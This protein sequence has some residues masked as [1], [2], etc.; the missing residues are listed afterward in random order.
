MICPKCGAEQVERPECARCGIVVAK[1][2]PRAP[3]KPAEVAP[4]PTPA[5]TSAIADAPA[6]HRQTPPAPTVF[7]APPPSAKLAQFY[8]QLGRQVAAG[9][10]L[11]DALA[12]LL[13]IAGRRTT[14]GLS[15][16]EL[17]RSR[18][19][20]AAEAADTKPPEPGPGE[21]LVL[22]M[23]AGVNYN[24]IWAGL[25]KPVSVLDVTKKDFHIAGSDA[26]GSMRSVPA[27]TVARDHAASKD[28]SGLPAD[29][30]AVMSAPW[31]GR[32][33]PEARAVTSRSVR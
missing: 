32:S 11:D 23:A 7:R 3:L 14:L 5:A 18:R 2:R 4:P 33:L 30:S 31:A 17:R 1:W 29:V 27:S 12:T 9:V 28:V 13:P 24:G 6:W 25:G 8:Q 22:V 15:I 21:A 10:G 19:D 26:A 20:R 16:A